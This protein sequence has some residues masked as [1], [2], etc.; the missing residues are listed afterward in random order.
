MTI[1]YSLKSS[2]ASTKFI[3]TFL[4]KLKL[5]FVLIQKH[6]KLNS[7]QVMIAAL[8]E[9]PGIGPTI[10]ELIDK[11]G[12]QR[13]LL[14]DGNSYDK[15]VEVAK[16]SGAEILYQNGKG[17][18]SAIFQGLKHVGFQTEYIVLIDA[19]YTYPAKY[20][21]LMVDIL[22]KKS[23]V[24]MVCGNRFNPLVDKR[25]FRGP[26]YFGNKFL[27]LAHNFVN[28]I[29]LHDPLTG[30]RV[31]RAELLKGWML[32]S[33]GFDIEVELNYLVKR[34][35][36]S[37]FEIPIEY[38]PRIGEKKLKIKDGLVIL[39]RIFKEIIISE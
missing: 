13:I 19:D 1:G 21:P 22:N 16:N 33:E 14:I 39:K 8:N 15:T 34:K 29:V 10:A 2:F 7:I 26:F 38:R 35:G 17:K 20:I 6:F 9:E 25:V 24:G 32:N 37:I 18:G 27:S 4:K 11:L 5:V 36:F 12:N 31:I 28:G 23:E 3:K 30:L